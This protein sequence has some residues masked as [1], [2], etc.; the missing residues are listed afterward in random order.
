MTLTW[1]RPAPG[2]PAPGDQEGRGGIG[3]RLSWAERIEIMRGRDRVLSYAEIGRRIGRDKAVVW[4]EVARNQNCGGDY[5][6]GMAHSRAAGRARR[7]KA[8]KAG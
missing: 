6:A 8:F 1:G 3:R 4:R 2:L 7:P 5:H